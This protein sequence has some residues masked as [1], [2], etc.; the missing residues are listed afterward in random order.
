MSFRFKWWHALWIAMVT[1]VSS[2]CS[3]LSPLCASCSCHQFCLATS[4]SASL[5]CCLLLCLFPYPP[6]PSVMITLKSSALILGSAMPCSSHWLV[7]RMLTRCLSVTKWKM[8][9]MGI[10]EFTSGCFSSLWLLGPC[11]PD[12]VCG[13]LARTKNE[14]LRLGRSRFIEESL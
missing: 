11:S 6:S 9:Q 13:E 12:L 1:S 8:I 10:E 3:H 7:L 4:V 5:C 2:S 14:G